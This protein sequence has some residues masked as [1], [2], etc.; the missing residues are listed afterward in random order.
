LDTDVLVLITTRRKMS[1]NET[2]YHQLKSKYDA[3]VVRLHTLENAS[4]VKGAGCS[5]SGSLYAH[6]VFNIVSKTISVADDRYLNTQEVSELA[7]STSGHDLV[8]DWNKK[9]D[10]PI[11][12]KKSKTPDWM[13]CVI[14]YDQKRMRW[15]GS[16]RCKIPIR[17][18]EY[19]ERLLGDIT[20]FDGDIPPFVTSKL[21]YEE[22]IK[23]KAS[24]SIF[25]DC[26]VDIPSNVIRKLYKFKGCKYIQISDKGLYHL[27]KDVC[28]FGVPKFV[29]EQRL[30][31][32]IKVHS[33]KTCSLS[34]TI[35]AQPKNI[36]DL[37]LSPYSLDDPNRLPKCL[38]YIG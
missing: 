36:T 13:Q 25:D 27:S 1:D 12:I 37:P 34:V 2:K 24:T 33:K 5:K 31:I 8:C 29:C 11:E 23:I 19:Y 26:Y 14:H 38:R 15:I 20:L 35:S 32:R 7:G 28:D 6:I 17:A 22:W 18:R 21:S 9:R 30:R 16:K 4:P 10:I 3:L